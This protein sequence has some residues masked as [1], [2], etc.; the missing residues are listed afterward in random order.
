ME[1]RRQDSRQGLTEWLEDRDKISDF[2][3]GQWRAREGFGAGQTEDACITVF[4][5]EPSAGVDGRGGW[6]TLRARVY[7]V[8][9]KHQS[10]G[11]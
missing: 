8:R 11:E 7:G 3:M 5:R 1:E 6:K 10:R 9:R 4:T 2:V